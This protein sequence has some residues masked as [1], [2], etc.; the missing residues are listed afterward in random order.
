MSTLF[1]V[2]RCTS[3]L[4]VCLSIT[5]CRVFD[6]F[7]EVGRYSEVNLD[8]DREDCRGDCSPPPY[9]GLGRYWPLRNRFDVR[10]VAGKCCQDAWDRYES[11]CRRSPSKHFQNGF[12]DAFYEIADGGDG[13]V[14]PIPPKKYWNAYYRSPEGKVYAQQWF[15]GYRVG[16]STAM[17]RGLDRMN[18][19]ATSVEECGCGGR[20]CP[21][22]SSGFGQSQ[23]LSPMQ[24]DR[25]WSAPG[26]SFSPIRE[27]G[28]GPIREYS[29]SPNSTVPFNPTNIPDPGTPNMLSPVPD[30]NV[31]PSPLIRSQPYS[32]P[33]VPQNPSGTFPVPSTNNGSNFVPNPGTPA[34]IPVPAPIPNGATPFI[35]QLP[36]SVP[37]PV[38]FPLPTGPNPNPATPIP[39]PTSGHPIPTPPF[40]QVT[41]TGAIPSGV[42]WPAQG[43]FY[44]PQMPVPQRQTAPHG[45]GYPDQVHPHQQQWSGAPNYPPANWGQP[46]RWTTN[47]GSPQPS[48]GHS[49]HSVMTPQSVMYSR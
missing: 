13:K 37:S 20:G 33:S 11:Q 16:A 40:N 46:A 7:G 12:R 15:N 8:T 4:L 10:D 32:G 2:L 25:F 21:S 38:P 19:I 35:P 24:G 44:Y 28:S 34:N 18:K 31:S 49:N 41:P 26:G 45:N 27:Y 22:C 17:E 42:N 47:A 14:P 48:L 23:V 1:A 29:S 6:F 43:G 30:S 3:L 9:S 39:N 5:G 36:S